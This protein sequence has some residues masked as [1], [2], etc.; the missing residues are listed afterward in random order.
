MTSASTFARAVG[1][2]PPLAERFFVMDANGE[3]ARVTE[4]DLLVDSSTPP[5]VSEL[6]VG[7]LN[8]CEMCTEFS[9]VTAVYAVIDIFRSV[10]SLAK[11]LSKLT[12]ELLSL[13]HTDLGLTY[14]DVF[15]SFL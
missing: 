13:S 5:H 2:Q 11:V 1:N 8:V 10:F 9:T 4:S 3:S 14:Q 7:S 6:E 12:K 15:S